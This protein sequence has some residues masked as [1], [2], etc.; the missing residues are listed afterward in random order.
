MAR[1][2][3]VAAKATFTTDDKRAMYARLIVFN[4]GVA[5]KIIS[6]DKDVN[7]ATDAELSKACDSLVNG[8][9]L[10]GKEGIELIQKLTMKGA[11]DEKVAKRGLTTAY[12]QEVRPFL[13]RKALAAS[14]GRRS[15]P[16]AEKPA[17]EKKAPAKK[18]SAK[19]S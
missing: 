11:T 18:E 1:K 12:A 9:M 4:H 10:E 17:A 2:T 13:R 15:K 14:F 19:K 7:S 6:K 5:E 3:E 8:N 16:K